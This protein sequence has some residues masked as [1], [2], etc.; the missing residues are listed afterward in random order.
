MRDAISLL[1]K[2]GSF[3]TDMSIDNALN[4]LGTYS[5]SMFFTLVNDIIDCKQDKVIETISN[6]YYEGKDLK[7]FVDQFFAFCLDVTKYCLFR[8]TDLL[9]IPHSQEEALKLSTNFENAEKY[10]MVI[11]DKLLKLKNMIKNDASMRTTVEAAF[12]NM[13]RWE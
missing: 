1:E 3:D 11:V 8:S 4:A 7:L 9:D 13:T 5:Y 6:I 12:L 10:Y 2:V